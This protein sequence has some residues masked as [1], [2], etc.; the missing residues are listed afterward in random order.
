[1]PKKKLLIDTNKFTKVF[2]EPKT[3]MI[4]YTLNFYF[5]LMI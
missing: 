3:E 2:F 5:K 4:E 1:M